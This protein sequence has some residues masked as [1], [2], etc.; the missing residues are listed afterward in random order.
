MGKGIGI[1]FVKEQ[2]RK[3]TRTIARITVSAIPDL[4]SDFWCYEDK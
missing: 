3:E 2:K 4:V 1:K